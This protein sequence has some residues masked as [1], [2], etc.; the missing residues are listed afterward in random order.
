MEYVADHGIFSD[1]P[2][3]RIIAACM[4]AYPRYFERANREFQDF[5]QQALAENQ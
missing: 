2:W 1:L 5:S 4:E 3:E